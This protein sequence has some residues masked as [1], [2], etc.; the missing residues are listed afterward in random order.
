MISDQCSELF[1]NLASLFSGVVAA[2]V[3]KGVEK[4]VV[5]MKCTSAPC[6]FEGPN[7]A[8]NAV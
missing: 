7:P 3:F 1:N 8:K 2:V 4:N 5:K 6:S